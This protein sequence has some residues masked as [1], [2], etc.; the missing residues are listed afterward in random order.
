MV[1]QITIGNPLNQTSL[2]LSEVKYLQKPFTGVLEDYLDK[3][4]S[5]D[6]NSKPCVHL[7]MVEIAEEER[8]APIRFLHL[9]NLVPLVRDGFF[10]VNFTDKK[11]AQFFIQSDK[12]VRS[13]IKK[14]H[15]VVL[16]VIDGFICSINLVQKTR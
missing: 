9:N 11:D 14:G 7:F 3:V 16:M 6:K 5:L 15:D 4:L 2:S 10:N 1:V 12:F 8:I 13:S